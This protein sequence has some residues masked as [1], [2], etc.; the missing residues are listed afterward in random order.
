MS[1][2]A[3]S[4]ALADLIESTTP[5]K[6]SV[7]GYSLGGRIALDLACRHPELVRALVLEGASPGIEGRG[8]RARRR[9]EDASLA[10]EIER[11][12]I[13]WF[14]EYWEERPLFA[15]QKALPDET[16]E[17]IRRDR[18]SNSA[19]GLAASLRAAG[20]GTMTPLWK[21]MEGLEVPV[22]LVVGKNDPKFVETGTAMK[23]RIPGS[24]LFEVEGA[25][26]CVHAE[27]PAEFASVVERF[28]EAAAA[29][30]RA[31]AP[32]RRSR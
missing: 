6:V 8:E 30:P 22:L 10:D 4:Q 24:R 17:S 25:G 13:E 3:T 12:G 27:K 2:E 29:T 28:L 7:V 16:V 1:V 9:A 14:V 21:S 5:G 11:R 18:L 19:Q 26:H 15:T 23:K 32:R 31:E 20:P